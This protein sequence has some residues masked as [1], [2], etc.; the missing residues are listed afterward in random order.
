MLF[1]IDGHG[2]EGNFGGGGGGFWRWRPDMKHTALS[3]ARGMG[4]PD[5]CVLVKASWLGPEVRVLRFSLLM[6][7][8][9]VLETT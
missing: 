4:G 3:L 5:S 8:R 9:A 6:K 2:S 1:L 7:V